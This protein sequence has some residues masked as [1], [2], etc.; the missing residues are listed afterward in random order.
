MFLGNRGA[1]EFL[2]EDHS[3]IQ[4]LKRRPPPGHIFRSCRE[5]RKISDFSVQNCVLTKERTEL[6][7]HDS[8]CSAVL[9]RLRTRSAGA[10]EES[11]PLSI[12]PELPSRPN[13][14]LC[15]L[16]HSTHPGRRYSGSNI[17]HFSLSESRIRLGQHLSESSRK[18]PRC[19]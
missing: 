15:K 5:D 13:A 3:I 1:Q 18:K 12:F 2:G 9:G 8:K 4:S 7:K 11:D 19:R 6:P 10:V 14:A 17:C 16:P